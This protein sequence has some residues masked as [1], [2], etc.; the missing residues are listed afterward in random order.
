MI[1]PGVRLGSH[2]RV[3]RGGA[4]PGEGLPAQSKADKAIWKFVESRRESTCCCATGQSPP[5]GNDVEI[6][7]VDPS[8]S[9]SFL[10]QSMGNRCPKCVTLQG[11]ACSPWRKLEIRL[12]FVEKRGEP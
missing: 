1:E 12:Q 4:W 3:G 6:Y 11:Q 2:P 7:H 9:I 8:L 10:W 5:F